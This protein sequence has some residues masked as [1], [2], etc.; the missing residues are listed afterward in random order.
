MT[1]Q[2]ILT[3]R[4]TSPVARKSGRRRAAFQVEMG[5]MNP[6]LPAT[7]SSATTMQRGARN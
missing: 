1:S 2:D 3:F 5:A 4:L 7:P 6:H